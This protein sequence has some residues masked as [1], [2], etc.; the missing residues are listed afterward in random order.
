MGCKQNDM[1][2]FWSERL[3]FQYEVAPHPLQALFCM[4]TE[5]APSYRWYTAG[6]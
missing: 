3:N 6:L 1:G 5:G 2:P 4:L